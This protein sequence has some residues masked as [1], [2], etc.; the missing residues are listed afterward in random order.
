MH[1]ITNKGLRRLTTILAVALEDIWDS[2]VF[3]NHIN[4][5]DQGR[6][7]LVLSCSCLLDENFW[8][9]FLVRCSTRGTHFLASSWTEL[10]FLQT[11]ADFARSESR[12][13]DYHSDE[14]EQEVRQLT[15]ALSLSPLLAK[16]CQKASVAPHVGTREGQIKPAVVRR[17][18]WVQHLLFRIKIGKLFFHT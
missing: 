12:E 10:Q 7:G 5:I 3:V 11:W 17:K 8:S 16:A 14:W 6:F 9:Y 13:N 1:I 18:A 2:L 15:L 4:F